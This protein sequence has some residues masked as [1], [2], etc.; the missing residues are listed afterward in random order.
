MRFSTMKIKL[1]PINT[2]KEIVDTFERLVLVH[3]KSDNSSN[4]GKKTKFRLIK[5]LAKK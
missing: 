1:Q 5:G 3:A 2:T 4:Q